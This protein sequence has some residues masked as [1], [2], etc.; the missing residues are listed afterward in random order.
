MLEHLQQLYNDAESNAMVKISTSTP[1]PF[2]R[3]GQNNGQAEVNA[4]VSF[5]D[6]DRFHLQNPASQSKLTI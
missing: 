3:I 5:L 2:C 4:K 1:R 6:F